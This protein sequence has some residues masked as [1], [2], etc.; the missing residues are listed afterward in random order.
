MVISQE[1]SQ[2]YCKMAL[3]VT[4]GKKIW[5]SIDASNAVRVMGTLSPNSTISTAISCSF[6]VVHFTRS[7]VHAIFVGTKG[8]F[9]L[10]NDSPSFTQ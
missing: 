4:Q 9:V 6:Q 1:E 3:F 8:P 2:F 5:K 10:F 7:A